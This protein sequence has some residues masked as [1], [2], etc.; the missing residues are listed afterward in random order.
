ML[1]FL[2]TFI[3]NTN[4]EQIAGKD[5]IFTVLFILVFKCN[6]FHFLKFNSTFAGV[7]FWMNWHN[8]MRS[9]FLKVKYMPDFY[10]YFTRRNVHVHL[11]S[12]SVN[13]V[14]YLLVF[15]SY[16]VFHFQQRCCLKYVSLKTSQNYE[17]I[18]EEVHFALDLQHY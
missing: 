4:F 6:V 11:I 17:N 10:V 12:R 8:L 15:R 18:F 13:T 14:S 1:S 3:S 16:I 5:W 9:F 2:L 7:I